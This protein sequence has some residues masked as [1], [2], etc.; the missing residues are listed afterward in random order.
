M[1]FISSLMGGAWGSITGTLSTQ[2]DL[3]S[4]LDAK[5]PTLVSGT[6]IKT[7][8]GSSLVGSG[9]VTIGAS[10]AI[11]Q[12]EVDFGSVPLKMKKFTV[13]DAGVSSGMKIIPT[14]SYD[15]PSDGEVDSAE[16]FEDM[17]IMARADTG[18]FFLYCNSPYKDLN[19][20]VKINYIFAT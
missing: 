11:Y 14:L 3:Q 12:T 5:Q 9:N 2:T 10:V 4:A 17:T 7:V 20:K 1:T 18:Q 16:W 13:T 8:N 6:N 19:G 15:T